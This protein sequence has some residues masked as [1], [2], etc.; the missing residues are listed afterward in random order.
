MKVLFLSKD[1]FISK[2]DTGGLLTAY[3][4]FKL[5]RQICGSDNVHAYILVPIKK[6]STSNVTYHFYKQGIVS[7]YVQYFQRREGLPKKDE[8]KIVQYIT[9]HHYDVVFFDGSLQGRIAATLPNSIHKVVFFHNVEQ[10][11]YQQFYQGGNKLLYFR[12]RSVCYNEGIMAEKMHAS[13]CLNQRDGELLYQYYHKRPDLIMPITF[14]DQFRMYEQKKIEYAERY[15]IF[16]GSYFTPNIQGIKWF[17][18]NVADDIGCKILV[19]GRGMELL[20]GEIQNKNVDIIGGVDSLKEYYWGAEA[21]IMPIFMGAGMKVK[22]AEA[23]MYGKAVFATH[24]ALEGY[25][26]ENQKFV[27][28]CNSPSDFID[29]INRYLSEHHADKMHANL[30]E[31]FLSKY[32]TSHYI[33]PLRNLLERL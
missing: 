18:K 12:Y 26:V 24:E 3:R 10:Y 22:T 29:S 27:Y 20:K 15:M 33:E 30:R 19:F 16:V 11:L 31:I 1:D 23:L 13:I 8:V 4:N 9:E 2:Q 5:V 17:C 7:R 28:E 14:E 25:E 6:D 32:E 21:V